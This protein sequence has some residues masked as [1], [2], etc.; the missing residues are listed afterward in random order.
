VNRA[1]DKGEVY[2]M[3]SDRRGDWHLTSTNT[4]LTYKNGH[5]SS[6]WKFQLLSNIAICFT[7]ACQYN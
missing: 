4:V 2:S 6:M 7:T 1:A 3:Y 5:H